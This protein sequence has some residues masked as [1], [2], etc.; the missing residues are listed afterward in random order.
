MGEAC[1]RRPPWDRVAPPERSAAASSA[2]WLRSEPEAQPLAGAEAGLGLSGWPAEALQPPQPPASFAPSAPR[3]HH[4]L[5]PGAMDAEP[6]EHAA[7]DPIEHQATGFHGLHHGGEPLR[8]PRWR[9]MDPRGGLGLIWQEDGGVTAC[10]HQPCRS[11]R[12]F[13]S[14]CHLSRDT[15]RRPCRSC[16]P[17]SASG[18]LP[19]LG[20][21]ARARLAR[22]EAARNRPQPK[23]GG[24]KRQTA[25]SDGR[26]GNMP[27]LSTPSA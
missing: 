25:T 2:G 12:R 3:R 10:W 13:A 4:L 14:L 9:A 11:S 26:S 23:R 21:L 24:Q 5:Q 18:P 8:V 17:P 20:L 1:C 16:F 7:V 19:R 15:G 22:K 6:G 27:R